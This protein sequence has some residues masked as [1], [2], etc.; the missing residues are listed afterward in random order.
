MSLVKVPIDSDELL[1]HISS[2]T[3]KLHSSWLY[4]LESPDRSPMAAPFNGDLAVRT[5]SKLVQ[6]PIA[7]R[8]VNLRQCP[9]RIRPIRKYA[10]LPGLRTSHE[11]R[12]RR[13]SFLLV[14]SVRRH[15]SQDDRQS[16]IGVCV[17][18]RS[19]HLKKRN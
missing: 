11:Q 2:T 15:R 8:L 10:G 17:H 18:T 13:D 19:T 6:I 7:R 3:G 16:R 9:F 14:C 4:L 12:Y 1:T 5:P